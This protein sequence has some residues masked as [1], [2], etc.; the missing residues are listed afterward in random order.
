[1]RPRLLS[2]LTGSPLLRGGGTVGASGLLLDNITNAANITGVWS[3]RK[4][5]SAYAGNCI[6]IRRS[7]DNTEQNF[8]FSAD[9]VDTAGIASFVGGGSGYVVTWYDQSGNALDVTQSTAAN[10]PLFV[11]SGINSKPSLDFDGSN[12]SFSRSSVPA[13]TLFAADQS[14]IMIVKVQP[15]GAD[16]DTIFQWGDA[17]DRVN[18]HA[19]QSGTFYFDFGTVASGRVSFSEA[20]GWRDAAHVIEVYRATGG[21]QQVLIDGTSKVSSSKSSGPSG[22]KT[23]SIA[24]AHLGS[25]NNTDGYVAEIIV[26]NADIGSTDRSTIRS[27]QGSYYGITVG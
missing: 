14:T 18:V 27:D 25:A 7:S 16:G 21:T 8:G 2:G 4:L 10:Q 3:L 26:C 22:T 1:M 24:T 9:V 6:R 13:T 5:K 20:A 19:V 15:T 12:D 11:A 23:L 17:T